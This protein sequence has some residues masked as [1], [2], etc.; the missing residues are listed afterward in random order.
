MS[1]MAK[2][3]DKVSKMDNA[4][5]MARKHA[6][7][8]VFSKDPI[9]QVSL[10]FSRESASLPLREEV[11]QDNEASYQEVPQAQPNVTVNF[12][13]IFMVFVAIIALSS[14]VM[15]YKLLSDMNI[16]REAA[17]QMIISYNTQKE[18]VN[19]LESLLRGLQEK[20]ALMEDRQASMEG[21]LTQGS[22]LLANLEKNMQEIR[23]EIS[24]LSDDQASLKTGLNDLKISQK[25]I[26]DK[27]MALDEGLKE[28]KEKMTINHIQ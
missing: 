21:Q 7:H 19:Q 12:S 26:F 10:G 4:S 17:K 6:E 2:L 1:K 25:V 11:M 8:A 20:Q 27:Y 16:N 14:I 13:V 28:I 23:G 22:N 18:K 24:T 3:L 9:Q 5:L 15:S